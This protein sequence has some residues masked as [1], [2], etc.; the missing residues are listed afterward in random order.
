[1]IPIL[2]N[3]IF[4]KKEIGIKFIFENTKNNKIEKN[5]C[6]YIFLKIYFYHNNN[7]IKNLKKLTKDIQFYKTIIDLY[8]NCIF[9]SFEAKIK[10]NMIKLA[11]NEAEKKLKRDS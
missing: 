8:L 6:E 2:L 1:M 3:K 9:I 11:V 4:I 10:L 5:I 7:I